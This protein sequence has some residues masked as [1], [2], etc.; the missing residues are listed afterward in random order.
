MS[1]PLSRK[2]AKARETEKDSEHNYNIGFHLSVFQTVSN[3]P[4]WV[5]YLPSMN[6]QWRSYM[7]YARQSNAIS[8]ELH[9][10]LQSIRTTIPNAKK[11]Q[12]QE[13]IVKIF[14]ILYTFYYVLGLSIWDDR[15]V[16]PGYTVSRLRRQNTNSIISQ[17]NFLTLRTQLYNTAQRLATSYLPHHDATSLG[18]QW[19]NNTLRTDVPAEGVLGLAM[20]CI[21]NTLLP[22]DSFTPR[23]VI[24]HLRPLLQCKPSIGFPL[25]VFLGLNEKLLQG[26]QV[27]PGTH[28]FPQ[29]S[30]RVQ[31]VVGASTLHFLS[32]WPIFER[33]HV[34]RREESMVKIP[35]NRTT[36]ANLSRNFDNVTRGMTVYG[37]VSLQQATQMRDAADQSLCRSLHHSQ[38]YKLGAGES[39]C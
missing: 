33:V 37:A 2:T 39:L 13:F 34:Q 10:V 28:N 11:G 7:L 1:N 4:L 16:Q 38:A 19:V 25:T 20:Q 23:E 14:R 8:A 9:T 3:P 6:E 27:T 31:Y 29:P 36:R 5:N 32:N 18:N 15:N 12:F 26:L 24:A 22:G 17:A 35:G 21:C 30:S